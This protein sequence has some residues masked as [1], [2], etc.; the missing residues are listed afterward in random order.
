MQISWNTPFNHSFLRR[1]FYKHSLQVL[2]CWPC[3]DQQ[4]LHIRTKKQ[5]FIRV[6]LLGQQEKTII[7]MLIIKLFV[8]FS[9]R[10]LCILQPRVLWKKRRMYLLLSWQ[11][12]K[13]LFS[14]LIMW[15]LL[16]KL[17]INCFRLWLWIKQLFWYQLFILSK[18]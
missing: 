2:W 11:L 4:Y 18:L 6:I 14:M 16:F 3:L 13:L 1:V 15:K 10:L 7:H 5:V 8:L 9:K 12:W 17:F